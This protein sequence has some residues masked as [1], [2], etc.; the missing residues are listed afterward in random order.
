[1]RRGQQQGRR[2]DGSAAGAFMALV[3]MLPWWAGVGLALV[4]YLVIH[5]GAA[6]LGAAPPAP[7]RP[8]E[9]T[10]IAMYGIKAAVLPI[11]QY[12]IPALCLFAAA[13]SA[14]HRQ[15]RKALARQAAA[16]QDGSQAL[17]GMSWREFEQLVGEAFRQRGY[18]ISENSGGGPDGGVDLVLR[19]G[20]EK[21][22]VQ[23]KQWRATQ[24]GVVIVREL[25][26][27]IAAEGATG[28]G[29]EKYGIHGIYNFQL[30]AIQFCKKTR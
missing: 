14:W 20:S 26:G 13:A 18:Q 6:N 3:A 17:N 27:L 5:A 12:L 24:V 19:K 11:L 30:H 9:A 7:T 15:Q 16:Q 1:M 4:S 10:A 29:N 23:C 28:G 22:L 21:W 25:Y 2:K 8:S